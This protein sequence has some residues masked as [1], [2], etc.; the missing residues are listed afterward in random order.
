MSRFHKLSHTLWHCKYHI[1]WTPKYRYRILTGAIGESICCALRSISE[2]RHLQDVINAAREHVFK[3]AERQAF[4]K[5]RAVV[6]GNLHGTFKRSY[7]FY[8]VSFVHGNSTVTGSY[9]GTVIRNGNA[10]HITAEIRYNFSDVFT[11]P[12]DIRERINGTSDPAQ[13]PNDA[14]ID[15]EFGGEFYTVYDSWTTELNAVIHIDGN[16][17]GY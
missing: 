16:K 14:L 6:S 10:L 12:F 13:I 2:A 11:D 1:I 4:E 5:A 15:G 8:S 3:G 7:P 9:S 17:S